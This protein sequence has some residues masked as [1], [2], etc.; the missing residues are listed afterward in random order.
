MY[1]GKGYRKPTNNQNHIWKASVCNVRY[2]ANDM[3]C[4][5]GRNFNKKK[6]FFERDTSKHFVD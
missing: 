6:T 4:D 2:Y 3:E 1:Q 5:M